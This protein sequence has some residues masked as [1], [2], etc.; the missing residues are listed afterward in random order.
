MAKQNRIPGED[1]DEVDLSALDQEFRETPKATASIPDGHYPVRVEHVELATTRS[2][3][4]PVLKWTLRPLLTEY[5]NRLLWKKSVLASTDGLKWLKHDLSL[6][7]IDL[8]KLSD[9]PAHL[10]RLVGVELHVTKRTRGDWENVHFNR[11]LQPG[12]AR[13]A[14]P[15][16]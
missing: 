11:R 4:R 10:P 12:T 13:D 15:A 6:C 5:S 9:L 14:D 16:F 7:G 8:D 1:D 2:S 3:R